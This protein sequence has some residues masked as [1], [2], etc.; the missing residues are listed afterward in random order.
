[1]TIVNYDTPPFFVAKAK[2][3]LRFISVLS[4]LYFNL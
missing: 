4:A 2:S 3:F 1:M